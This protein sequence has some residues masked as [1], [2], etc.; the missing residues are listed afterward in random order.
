MSQPTRQLSE[1]AT[2]IPRTGL[3]YNLNLRLLW[4]VTAWMFALISSPVLSGCFLLLGIF[5]AKFSFRT[6]QFSVL[7]L[8]LAVL[9]L[10]HPLVGKFFAIQSWLW[11]ENWVLPSLG[12]G[13]LILTLNSNRENITLSSPTKYLALVTSGVGLIVL[14]HAMSLETSLWVLGA[15]YDNS[16]HF[17]DMFEAVAQPLVAI[18]FP[19]RPPRTFAIISALVIRILGVSSDTT[20]LALFPWY[21]TSIFALTGAF[22]YMII[23][24]VAKY[25]FSCLLLLGATV[26]TVLI[27][28]LTPVSQTFVSGNPT[29]I[30]AI[31]LIFYYLFPSFLLLTHWKVNVLAIIGSLYLINSSYPFTLILLVPVVALYFLEITAKKFRATYKIIR[32]NV[33]I[34]FLSQRLLLIVS[35]LFIFLVLLFAFSSRIEDVY[36]RNWNQFLSTF[37]KMGG[38]EPYKQQISFVLIYLLFGLYSVNLAVLKLRNHLHLAQKLFR[39]NSYL[40][41]MGLG[42]L[43]VALVVR[44]YSETITDGGTYYAMK[45]S[46]SAAIIAFVA[47]VTIAAGLTQAFAAAYRE[48]K[49]EYG[50]SLTTRYISVGVLTIICLLVSGG[51]SLY[52]AGQEP[53]T[54]FRR[55]YMGTIP[56]FISEFNDPGSS[57]INASLVS[58]AVEASQRL[59]RPV[60]L[61][62]DGQADRLGTIW[63]NEISGFW[64]YR[65][66]ESI[67]HVPTALSA[68]DLNL[69]AEFFTDLRMI[70][71]T[72]DETLLRNMRSRVPTLLGCT[73]TQLG[74]RTCELQASGTT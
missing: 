22:V 49:S 69:V 42:A 46:Y 64:T 26:G 30:F 24:T 14:A 66:W 61:V 40:T 62:T 45:L 25:V 52:R 57:G 21:L 18:P 63:A 54:Y 58:Y 56:K 4:L 34:I 51:Y 70:L 44:K 11:N 31:F 67:N 1:L 43:L 29:Q 27:I 48:R 59:N 19:S 23:K 3:F 55:A 15:G 36:S 50:A 65:L 53:A 32:S 8:F 12:F 35:G 7:G 28:S 17:R 60:F 10:V 13:F 16:T 68:G 47:V 9:I 2:N 71:I 37:S 20:T 74:D 33:E 39:T 72:D 41:V 38:I 5:G 73:V 6:H